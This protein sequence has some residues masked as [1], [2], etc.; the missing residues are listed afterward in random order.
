MAAQ[1][2][3]DGTIKGYAD[4]KIQVDNISTTVTNNKTA[5]DNAFATLNNTT[6]P[7]IKN[8]IKSAY[9]LA[10]SAWDYADNAYDLA[11]EADTRSRSSA[12]W[13]SQHS[14]R[15]ELVSAQFDKNGNLTNTSGLVTGNGSFSS[16][17]A[18]ALRNDGTVAKVA[19]ITV[20]VDNYG[21]S[22]AAIR[23]DHINFTTFDWEVTNPTTKKTIFH[24]DSNG[25]LTIAGKFHGE[26][27]DAVIVGSGNYKMYIR[28]KSSGAELVGVDTDN[29]DELLTLGFQTSGNYAFPSLDMHGRVGGLYGSVSINSTGIFVNGEGGSVQIAANNSAANGIF[30]GVSAWNEYGHIGVKDNKFIIEGTWPSYSNINSTSHKKGEVYADDNGFLKIKNWE[31]VKS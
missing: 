17:F 18:S 27:D 4:L 22:K 30:F 21:T 13:I 25:N 19:D 5:A 24:L 9:N 12:T 16:L 1:F 31:G 8:D 26:F 28:P 11:D 2:N 15:I 29:D 23:A 3:A 14:D 7:G 6:L 10:D 20:F